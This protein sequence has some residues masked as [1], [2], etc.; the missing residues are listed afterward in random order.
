[1]NYYKSTGSMTSIHKPPER[2]NPA[3]PAVLQRLANIA[4][5]ICQNSDS[6]SI[7]KTMRSHHDRSTELIN[8]TLS[9]QTSTNFAREFYL[10][11]HE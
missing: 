1:M 9:W 8:L 10:S 11:D 2:R 7:C 5:S 3:F 4:V 6:P